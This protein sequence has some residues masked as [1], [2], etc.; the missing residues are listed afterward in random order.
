M[1]DLPR[2]PVV[3]GVGMVTALGN[4]AA[5]VWESCLSGRTRVCPI[6][7]NWSHYYQSKSKYWSPLDLPDYSAHGIRKS[8][9]LSLDIAV[10]N[11]MVASGE[12]LRHANVELELFDERQGRHRPKYLDA[13]RAGI[14]MGSGLGCITTTLTNYVPHLL[15][16]TSERNIE[17][18][19][20]ELRR[21]LSTHPRVNPFAS[22]KSMPNAISAG[23]SI[24]FGFKG[25]CETISLACAAGTAAIA[26]A[27]DAIRLDRL[28]FAL[29][30]GSEFYGDEA[31]GV[32][33][34]FDRL[35]ALASGDFAPAQINRPFDTR[36]SGFL[37]SQGAACVI[38]IESLEH[39][40]A[41]GVRPIARILGVGRSSDAYSMA[42]MS[43]EDQAIGDMISRAVRDSGLDVTDIDYV[44]AHGTGTLGNDET[45]AEIIAGIFGNNV[46][47]NST[48]SL[49]GHTIGASGAI[50][51]ALTAMTIDQSTV[52]GSLN[53][54]DPVLD[55][56]F[57]TATTRHDVR[58]ALTQSFGFG[59][60]NCG[61]VLAEV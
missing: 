55:M 51:C 12:A 38:A 20:K 54:D 52:H 1:S 22:L 43:G 24:R 56:N 46:L 4:S 49:L 44:N 15:R 11:A 45:E 29:A 16:G 3:T 60:H 53:I 25:E 13:T 5:E 59:G 35:N 19:T 28:D 58:A 50:E 30:G 48:K 7:E 57:A 18:C 47:V 26:H 31:G 2:C 27:V 23:P 37:F 8:E 14:F 42:A 36:R 40:N 10:L 6:P 9:I 41:R 61:L 39:A 32:F 33:M 21:N 17:N 34:A